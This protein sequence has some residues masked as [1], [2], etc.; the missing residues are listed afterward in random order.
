MTR[1]LVT[2]GPE[3]SGK[4]T[5][6]T[7]LSATLHCPLVMEAS[8]DYLNERYRTQPGYEYGQHDLLQIARLQWQ[9][10][11]VA[12]QQATPFVV[13]DTDL[14]VILVWSEVRYGHAEPALLALFN[15]SLAA[16]PRTY[17]LCD[18]DIPWEPDP[19]REHPQGRDMLAAHY[20]SKLREL[21]VHHVLAS[22]VPEQRLQQVVAATTAL[23]P[24]G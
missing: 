22:G 2:T 3:S 17:L 14:L 21:G 13:C 8:R 7:Q 4:T 9:R 11:Q 20:R 24:R 19:L 1:L 23:P 16:A 12:L 18:H 6:A 15:Q 5:L 10:E